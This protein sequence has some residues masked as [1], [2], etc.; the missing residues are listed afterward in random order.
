M[1]SSFPPAFKRV[2][3]LFVVPANN[4]NRTNYVRIS[5]IITPPQC[6]RKDSSIAAANR[7]IAGGMSLPVVP[8]AEPLQRL[9]PFGTCPTQ[10][11]LGIANECRQSTA[12]TEIKH[13]D[14]HSGG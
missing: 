14:N 8:R 4:C 7:H 1:E 3:G 13:H 12:P 2:R 11:G 10:P 5:L 9:C 6:S